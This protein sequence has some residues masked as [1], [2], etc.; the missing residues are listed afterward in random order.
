MQ[1]GLL[2]L[3]FIISIGIVSF[4]FIL[5]EIK[6]K[7]VIEIIGFSILLVLTGFAIN[8]LHDYKHLGDTFTL[9]EG[10]YFALGRLLIVIGLL[11]GIVG[12]LSKSN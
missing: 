5:K 7:A 9:F 2:F 12:F 6:G 10:I 3:L 11:T 8:E 1:Q 4:I